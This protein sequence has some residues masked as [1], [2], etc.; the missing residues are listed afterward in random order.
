MSLRLLK[1]KPPSYD[2][3][4][5]LQTHI[6][7]GRLEK[8]NNRALR[9]PRHV[10]PSLRQRTKKGFPERRSARSCCGER[11]KVVANPIQEESQEVFF[12]Q[13]G[14]LSR[15]PIHFFCECNS[16]TL[17][18]T[19]SFARSGTESYSTNVPSC[20]CVN[21][22]TTRISTRQCGRKICGKKEPSHYSVL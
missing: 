22:R 20:K 10:F 3:H 13:N 19:V 11:K 9:C 16:V 18:A 12:W 21:S 5:P 1:Q 14:S 4:C 2:S 8:A 6:N 15:G 7:N 17:K